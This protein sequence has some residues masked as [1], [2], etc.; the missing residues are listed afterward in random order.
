MMKNDAP[1]WA[2]INVPP[3]R[4]QRDGISEA[5]AIA[6]ISISA[7]I[8]AAVI[9]GWILEKIKDK[10]TTTITIN[11]TLVEFEKGEIIR[12]IEETRKIES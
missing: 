9:A 11:R 12:V 7:S 5:W 3:V 1:D 2:N 10:Q 8:P 4:E 6:I